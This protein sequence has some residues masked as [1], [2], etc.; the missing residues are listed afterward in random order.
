MS[1]KFITSLL[2]AGL[3]TLLVSSLGLAAIDPVRRGSARRGYG[4]ITALSADSLT[5]KTAKGASFTVQLDGETVYRDNQGGLVSKADLETGQKVAVAAVHVDEDSWIARL[6]MILPDDFDPSQRPG[7]GAI[8]MVIAVGEESFTLQSRRGDELTFLVDEGTQFPGYVKNLTELEVGMH[9]A[10]AAIENS[11]GSLVALSVRARPVLVKRVG[12]ITAVDV[13]SRTLSLKDRRGEETT[14]LV[15]DETRFRSKNGEISNLEDVEVGMAAVVMAI[16]EDGACV[17][18][19]VGVANKDDLPRFDVKNAGK[20]VSIDE[21]SFTIKIRSGDEVTFLVTE[22]TK[23]RSRG[24][25]ID[26]FED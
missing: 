15:N 11:D 21:D 1:K 22:E 6:V 26:S 8:G 25:R 17:A 18:I 16:D 9:A 3:T 2:I 19:G 20:I 4:E 10:V 5:L 12:V 14:F 24:D 13:S 23:Y 7:R